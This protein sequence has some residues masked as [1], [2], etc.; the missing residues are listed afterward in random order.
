MPCGRTRGRVVV[1]AAA[2][3]VV[4]VV[5]A[6]GGEAGETESGEGGGRALWVLESRGGGCYRGGRGGEGLTSSRISFSTARTVAWRSSPD[7][8]PPSPARSARDGG[9]QVPVGRHC[10]R[11]RLRTAMRSASHADPQPPATAPRR[12]TAG[13][14]G[15]RDVAALG[16][17]RRLAAA[18]TASSRAPAGG[19]QP[20]RRLQPLRRVLALAMARS[21]AVRKV[22]LQLGALKRRAPA[23]RCEYRTW[24][25][26]R[27]SADSSRWAAAAAGAPAA[28]AARGGAPSPPAS[29]SLPPP[30]P[31]RRWRRRGPR[32]AAR[33]PPGTC[34]PAGSPP[35]A[36]PAAVPASSS[37]SGPR[38]RR[39][40]GCRGARARA[41]DLLEPGSA[42]PAAR[43]G[44]PR[45]GRPRAPRPRR[46]RA[47]GGDAGRPRPPPR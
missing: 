29:S 33:P 9:G 19:A 3:V 21:S 16:G 26:A 11:V 2:A 10:R 5:V 30:P 36:S 17:R 14:I 22:L 39:R 13:E 47:C 45:A 20:Q 4:E 34:P 25:S 42:A 31:R 24:R 7:A 32:P 44:R 28:A 8:A 43:S 35:G 6:R 46:A 15:A 27:S 18:T 41:K 40:R 37:S 38:R 23:P 1:V 12:A